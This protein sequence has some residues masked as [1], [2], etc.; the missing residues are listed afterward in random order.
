METDTNLMLQLAEGLKYLGKGDND[1]Y[2]LVCADKNIEE[3]VINENTVH[4]TDYVLADMLN[5]KTIVI[6]ESVEVIVFN[7]N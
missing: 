5:M 1:Y 2:Y 4:I 7:C 3:V 6:P